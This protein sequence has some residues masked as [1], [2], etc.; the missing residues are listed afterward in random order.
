MRTEAE[1][2]VGFVGFFKDLIK[3][4]KAGPVFDDPDKIATNEIILKTR[5]LKQERGSWRVNFSKDKIL[6]TLKRLS[7][8]GY[9]QCDGKPSVIESIFEN[10][11]ISTTISLNSSKRVNLTVTGLGGSK[12]FL[13]IDDK[14]IPLEEP[15]D[16]IDLLPIEFCRLEKSDSK[17]EK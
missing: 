1:N 13:H 16:L 11:V 10:T 14:H 4:W 3:R 2:R 6:P 7:E 15:C 12:Q 17:I 5:Q 9:L 8:E